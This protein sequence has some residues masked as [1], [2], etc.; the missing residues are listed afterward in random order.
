MADPQRRI[1]QFGTGCSA[2]PLA[3]IL[4]QGAAPAKALFLPL[5]RGSVWGRA[6]IGRCAQRSE[7]KHAFARCERADRRSAPGVIFRH[8][9]AGMPTAA[10]GK[11]EDGVYAS[12]ARQ[13]QEKGEGER[14]RE[15]SRAY[16]AASMRAQAD[17]MSTRLILAFYLTV[18]ATGLH[19]KDALPDFDSKSGC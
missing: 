17:E 1:A 7:A 10:Y 19:F 11:Q 3:R 6:S 2:W 13:G 8:C 14:R 5:P 4:H 15:H 18:V 16:G 9:A 12:P